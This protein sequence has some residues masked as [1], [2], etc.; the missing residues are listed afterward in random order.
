MNIKLIHGY[1][2]ATE[3]IE[4]IT[5]LIHI[6]I[7]YH[8]NKINSTNDQEAKK[9]LERKII[10]L[11]KDLFEIRKHIKYK[12]NIILIESTIEVD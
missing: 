1:Y 11:Q 4:I 9:T 5:Q 6:K 3:A 2:N 10:Q 12:G 8:E 7:K